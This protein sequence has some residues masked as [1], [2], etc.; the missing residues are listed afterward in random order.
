MCVWEIFSAIGLHITVLELHVRLGGRGHL[1]LPEHSCVK[2]L[3]INRLI[4]MCKAS[5]WQGSEGFRAVSELR[6]VQ[7]GIEG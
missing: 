3:R 4:R 1:D 5:L 2:C 6:A 7:S